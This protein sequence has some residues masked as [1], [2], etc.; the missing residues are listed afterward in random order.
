MDRRNFVACAVMLPAAC[1]APA[2]ALAGT[3]SLDEAGLADCV[4]RFLTAREAAA[5]Y[6]EDVHRPLAARFRAAH[7]AIPHDIIESRDRPN[8]L[9][10]IACALLA[11]IE[12][13]PVET[14]AGL[15]RKLELVEE[16]DGEI[17]VE[18][19]TADVR[20]IASSGRA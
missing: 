17:T 8:E 10:G 16:C 9:C 11:D 15:L 19:I 14:M 4:S 12:L 2:P 1:A 18:I 6:D 5:R 3:A 20:R 7:G 13:Y